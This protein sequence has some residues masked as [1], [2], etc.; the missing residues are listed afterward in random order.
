MST[1][2][3][4]PPTNLKNHAG[5]PVIVVEPALGETVANRYQKRK[6]SAESVASLAENIREHGLK[7]IPVGRWHPERPGMVEFADGHRRRAAF[8][9][10]AKTDRR[11]ARIPV[12]LLP[13]TDRELY[14]TCVITNEQ[15]EPLSAIERAISL[16]DYMAEFKASQGVAGQLFNIGQT[17]VSHLIHMLDLP[18]DVQALVDKRELPERA[19]RSLGVLL[20]WQAPDDPDFGRSAV[21]KIAG[22]AIKDYP[23]DPGARAPRVEFLIDEALRRGNAPSLDSDYYRPWPL[24]WPG[25]PIRVETRRLLGIRTAPAEVPACRGCPFHL[26]RGDSRYC[27]RPACFDVKFELWGEHQVELASERLGIAAAGEGETVHVVWGGEYSFEKR[28]QAAK[29]VTSKHADL[30][31]VA[32]PRGKNGT[33]D[34]NDYGLVDVLGTKAVMLATVNLAAIERFVGAPKSKAAAPVRT[35]NETP[36]QAERRLNAE[37]EL[38]EE[39]ALERMA[40]N[41]S[42]ADVLW[43]VEHT[44]GLIAERTV[45]GGGMLLFAIAENRGSFF[46]VTEEMREATEA[47]A[48]QTGVDQLGH[49][50][51][52]GE[53][54]TRAAIDTS[55]PQMD[56]MRRRYLAY[57][58]LTRDVASGHNATDVYGDFKKALNACEAV[59]VDTFG[60]ALPAGW[61]VPPVHRTPINCWTCGRFSPAGTGKL[62]QSDDKEGWR[63]LYENGKG[64][65]CGPTAPGAKL[66]GVWCP[67]H[68]PAGIAEWNR[69]SLKAKGQAQ[70]AELATAESKAGS[71]GAAGV[72]PA[73][74]REIVGVEFSH[75]ELW[76]KK[77]NLATLRA[78]LPK[79]PASGRTTLLHVAVER[80]IKK[81]ET[82]AP[83]GRQSNGK[84][85]AAAA[86][87][88]RSLAN[89]IKPNGRG[90]TRPAPKAAAAK[91]V[92][93]RRKISRKG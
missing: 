23:S 78:V 35:A 93:T 85:A 44:A 72:D 60:I 20:P 59:A 49:S 62:T 74:M 77:A 65:M 11:F 4:A 37:K 84:A 2:T 27:L 56:Q 1:A 10:L 88:A 16:R 92:A 33:Y 75:A 9:L 79:L 28:Q 80:R 81:L 45:A 8:E 86:A 7:Q 29:L 6:H 52:A 43:I 17:A 30:R 69:A 87:S 41:R 54:G 25:K 21:N 40:Y 13:L 14:E 22:Q 19:A 89:K 82:P 5:E 38:R 46:G 55:T 68:A 70:D 34:G 31:L 83:A 71:N 73:V 67:Q 53:S 76:I 36:A 57:R 24:E 66:A 15:R 90:H 64:Q 50:H 26:K 42:R 63:S 51:G 47:L 58:K 91:K 48:K 18:D 61:H 39:R 3:I 32:R 12:Q